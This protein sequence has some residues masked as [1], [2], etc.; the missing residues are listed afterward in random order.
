MRACQRRAFSSSEASCSRVDRAD[1][2]CSSHAVVCPAA[3]A[4]TRACLQARLH[5]VRRAW[6]VGSG[7]PQTVQVDSPSRARI[8]PL[9]RHLHIQFS[10][11]SAP[12]TA[13][14]WAVSVH[15]SCH[16]GSGT[17]QAVISAMRS[18]Q[19]TM[20]PRGVRGEPCG[21]HR[22]PGSDARCRA[23]PRAAWRHGR[24]AFRRG[25]GRR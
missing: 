3:R 16:G 11:H 15:T 25:G 7:A 24:P 13:R 21:S 1:A 9:N 22:A 12:R 4:R 23:C 5:D 8:H 14:A 18:C 6:L 17:G 19:L 10:S 2:T 20:H